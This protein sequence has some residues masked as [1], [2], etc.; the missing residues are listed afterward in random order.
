[1]ELPTYYS[2]IDL[3]KRTSFIT[4]IDQLGQIVK[5]QQLQNHREALKAYF[6]SQPGV[7]LAVVEST[8]GWYWL[9]D[10]LDG[11]GIAL[12]LAH[13]KYLKAISYAKVKTDK[14]DSETLAHLLRLDMIP[15]AHQISAELRDQRD[16]LRTRLRLV[17]RRTGCLNSVQR[18]LEKF[19]QHDV[20]D[21]PALYQLQA[22]C[23][24]D[25]VEL[26][27]EQIK[28]L[29]KALHP[30]LVP[31]ADVQRLLRIPGIGKTNAFTIYLETDGIERFATDKQFFSYCRLVPGANNSGASRRHRSGNKEGNRY[32]KMA[33][34]HASAKAIQ[35]YGEIRTFYR[36]KRRSKGEAIAR[37]L[38][39]KE[40]ARIVYQVLTKEERFNGRF[41]GKPLS[42]VKAQQW[43]LLPSP[44]GITGAG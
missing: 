38:V 4:T 19:N 5:Q 37:T 34:S 3:H 8:T 22:R 41:K 16:V 33:F 6:A 42:R 25:Q 43:P 15:E 24:L 12:K 17:S 18:L 20:L 7:H 36:S 40:L 35:Y 11:Q 10:L 23:H 13:A 44:F 27:T 28:A 21:L 9:R 2:G 14:V 26:L 1:M 29:E 30:T 32:L 39:A 31:N